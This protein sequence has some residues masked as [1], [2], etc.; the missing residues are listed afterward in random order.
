M[1]PID[2]GERAGTPSAERSFI[3][4]YNLIPTLLEPADG[5]TPVFTPTFRWTAVRG[6]EFYKLQYSTNS[7]F[8]VAGHDHRYKEYLIHT[9]GY[10]AQ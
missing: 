1:V 7:D 5:A 10:P 4:G 2:P 8:S 9:A 6:A 3:A